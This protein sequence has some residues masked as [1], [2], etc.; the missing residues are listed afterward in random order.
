MNRFV[1]I[2]GG[3]KDWTESGEVDRGGDTS[4]TVE[5]GVNIVVVDT[6]K[7]IDRGEGRGSGRGTERGRGRG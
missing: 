6:E 1:S 5:R 7:G 3:I 4:G 2:S